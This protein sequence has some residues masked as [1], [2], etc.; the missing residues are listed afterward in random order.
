[1]Q[2]YPQTTPCPGNIDP[3][4]VHNPVCT[5]CCCVFSAFSILNATSSGMY[6]TEA[7]I[8]GVVAGDLYTNI[9]RTTLGNI[10]A[11]ED[12]LE[13]GN[14]PALWCTAFIECIITLVLLAVAHRAFTAVSQIDHA[15]DVSTVTMS[16]YT[17][18]IK[19]VGYCHGGCIY[20]G[21]A[22]GKWEYGLRHWPAVKLALEEFV[23]QAA[24][25][26]RGDSGLKKEFHQVRVATIEE[27]IGALPFDCLS[28]TDDALPFDCLSLTSHCLSSTAVQLEQCEPSVRKAAILDFRAL[29]CFSSGEPLI[30]ERIA[31]VG[32]R[33]IAGF[34]RE[35]N[36]VFELHPFCFCLFDMSMFCAL[37]FQQHTN[38]CVATKHSAKISFVPH[39]KTNDLGCIVQLSPLALDNI[40]TLSPV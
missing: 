23:T 7:A 31:A 34:K 28:L 27:P 33:A 4:T 25:A 36:A 18:H 9:A 15:T 10:Y 39:K 40:F 35:S 21:A 29:L 37:L 3:R 22:E 12:Q 17:V 16:D 11:T 38:C 19:P 20:G 24:R 30:E 26:G 8:R 6:D 5:F 1:M 14:V 13:Q 2:L 32:S